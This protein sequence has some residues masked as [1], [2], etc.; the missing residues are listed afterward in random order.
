MIETLG[1]ELKT[2]TIKKKAL[3]IRLEG[4]F[5]TQATIYINILTL[6]TDVASVTLVISSSV[7]TNLTN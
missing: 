1:I 4:S 3:T 7:L 6:R 5:V 2:S